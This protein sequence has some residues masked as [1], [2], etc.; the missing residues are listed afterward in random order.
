MRQ[1]IYIDTS[2]IGGYYD[3]EFEEPT[4]QLFDRIANKDFDIYFSEV[5]ETELIL[6]P[7]HIQDANPPRRGGPR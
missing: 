4:K 7:Q 2:V 5:N 6:A 1:R 3:E